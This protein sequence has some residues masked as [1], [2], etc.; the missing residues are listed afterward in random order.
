MERL[1]IQGG[2]EYLPFARSRIRALKT[3]G[4]RYVSQT[5]T[6]NGVTINVRL[7]NG[8]E[9]IRIDGGGTINMESGVID[10]R[11]V[12]FQNT[13]PELGYA[14]PTNSY[15]PAHLYH[16]AHATSYQAPFT[17]GVPP[18]LTKPGDGGQF[19]GVIDG[20]PGNI[21]GH[22]NKEDRDSIAFSPGSL[23]GD[24]GTVSTNPSDSALAEKRWGARWCP[25]SIFTG[26]CRMYVQALMG[27][28]LYTDPAKVSDARQHPYITP[29]PKYIPQPQL[30]LPGS[31]GKG[32]AIIDT[33]TGVIL[34][35]TYYSHWLFVVRANKVD[36]YPLKPSSAGK[37]ALQAL[38]KIKDPTDFDHMEAYILSESYPV[39]A[40]K[41]EIKV[42]PQLPMLGCGYGWHWAWSTATADIVVNDRFDQDI[43][44]TAMRSTHFRIS[45][46]P[47]YS[48]VD[49]KRTTTWNLTRTTVSGPTDWAA[50]FQLFCIA[51]PIFGSNYLSK[52]LP[53]YSNL[54]NCTAP[55]YVFY[56]R[57]E[58]QIIRYSGGK[59][60]SYADEWGP[61]SG[62]N[63]RWHLG[64]RDAGHQ[65]DA[66]GYEIYGEFTGHTAR[67]NQ[68][69]DIFSRTALFNKS[70]AGER[71][72][73]IPALM[74]AVHPNYGYPLE[75]DVFT[76]TSTFAYDT[77][78]RPYP[79]FPASVEYG[80]G[81]WR[82]MQYINEQREQTHACRNVAAVPFFDAEAVYFYSSTQTTTTQ[83]YKI[84]N[85][86]RTAAMTRT[87]YVDGAEYTSYLWSQYDTT[88]PIAS[89]NPPPETNVV[90]TEDCKLFCSNGTFPATF[91]ASLLWMFW[92]PMSEVV[93][94]TLATTSGVN[95]ES[96]VVI[97]DGYIDAV[98]AGAGGKAALP[99]IVGWA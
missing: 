20:I 2:H 38:R 56:K 60:E 25:P 4:M 80:G 40:D 22:V 78:L 47:Y 95:Q 5:Y 49:G 65:V 48:E 43:S 93:S 67:T 27:S 51:H 34:D 96:P 44:H 90:N 92:D 98:G 89:S 23:A 63:S 82:T 58:I 46:S 41:Q 31:D 19:A 29:D 54:F 30:Y 72:D 87:D 8:T 55:F 15:D 7:E 26:K 52:M 61:T 64:L 68:R 45:F 36:V 28:P 66:K 10:L 76:G 11:S 13:D 18:R 9:Y 74:R 81:F 35:K 17:R 16:S 3:L 79:A 57:D 1:L 84:E 75:G 70:G 32:K 42:S 39:V 12:S 94:A 97:S 62:W 14:V 86:Y 73:G 50:H 37:A 88:T 33:S 71:I 91:S 21:R 99:I 59:N 6:V 24:D 53:K 77:I 69:H 83:D 85:T